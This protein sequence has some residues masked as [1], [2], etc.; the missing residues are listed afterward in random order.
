M[1]AY[2]NWGVRGMNESLATFMKIAAVAV[3][4]AALIWSK[5]MGVMSDIA[6]KVAAIIS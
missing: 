4:I 5:L 2:K 6:D 1:L 3:V